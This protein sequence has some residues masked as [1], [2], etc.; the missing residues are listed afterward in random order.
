MA[1]TSAART[2]R[3]ARVNP[4]L[5]YFNQ[6]GVLDPESIPPVLVTRAPLGLFHIW[7][8]G[9]AYPGCYV[10]MLTG[11]WTSIHWLQHLPKTGAS[12]ARTGV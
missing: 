2:L 11:L 1:T 8:S 3:M 4:S 9:P 12:F 5:S 6:S 7:Q 10:L